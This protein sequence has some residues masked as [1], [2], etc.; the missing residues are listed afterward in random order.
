MDH[1]N[2]VSTPL[3]KRDAINDQ[4][5]D[6]ALE[7]QDNNVSD[8]EFIDDPEMYSPGICHPL[9]VTSGIIDTANGKQAIAVAIHVPSGSSKD[10]MTVR[11]GPCGRVLEIDY[12]W[13]EVL[14]DV[15]T[16]HKFRLESTKERKKSNHTIQ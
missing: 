6:A 1:V 8:S 12:V 14:T 9:C 13:P 16:L 5:S 7:N 2:H 11:V 10:D 3:T 15:S 4:I